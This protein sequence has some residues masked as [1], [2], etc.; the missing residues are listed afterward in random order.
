MRLSARRSPISPTLRAAAIAGTSILASRAALPAPALRAPF[1]PVVWGGRLRRTRPPYT[2]VD[3]RRVHSSEQAATSDSSVAL[4]L[5]VVC[6]CG[7][8]LAPA[9]QRPVR[10]LPRRTLLSRLRRPSRLG[11]R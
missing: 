1:R 3:G 11:L 7:P 4:H 8:P 2:S 9:H 5:A 10:L 6:L